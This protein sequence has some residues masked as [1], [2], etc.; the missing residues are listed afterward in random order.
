MKKGVNRPAVLAAAAAVLSLSAAFYYSAKCDR[1][2]RYID[3]SGQRALSDLVSELSQMDSSLSK[4]RYAMPGKSFQTISADIWQ[5][6]ENAKSSMAVLS[7][8]PG[9]LD[10]TQKFV[11]QAGDFAF[12]LLSSSASGNEISPEH[13]KAIDSLYEASEVITREISAVKGQVNSGQLSVQALKAASYDTPALSL[14]D[15][16][17][18]LEQEFPEYATL[19]YDGPFSE[20]LSYSSPR[21]LEGLEEISLEKA[22]NNASAFSGIPVTRLSLLTETKGVIPTYCL[23]DENGVTMEV[24]KAGGIIYTYKNP[25]ALGEAQITADEAIEKAAAFLKSHGFNN[26]KESYYSIYDGLITINFAY[27]ESDIVFYGDLIKVSVALDNGEVVGMEARGFLMSHCSRN[28]SA[29]AVSPEK[30]AQ[31][32]SPS[33]TVKSSGL[34]TIPTSGENEVLCYEYLCEN[35]DGLHVI[36]YINAQSGTQE[37][38]YIL[39]EDENGT[40]VM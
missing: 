10:Q 32:V 26:M 38:I 30:A 3:Y 37:N 21:L 33:L 13:L 2:E 7:T 36:I 31:G 19:I 12:F 24:S 40:L 6:A 39:L 11:S 25:R 15:G 20:H 5:A 34:A 8:D 17:S 35:S 27:T 18:G 4:L 29:P 23:T 9:A 22:M 14:S 1:Y 28:I 16:F